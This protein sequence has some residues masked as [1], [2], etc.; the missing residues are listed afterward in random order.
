MRELEHITFGQ[1]PAVRITSGN[2]AQAVVTLFG[3]HI[4][5]WTP[6]GGKEQ[7]FCSSCSALD[8][9]KAIR[10]G[11][12]LIFPQFSERGS[13]MRH[14]FAR[15]S[16]WRLWRSGNEG[17]AGFAEFVLDSSDR[18]GAPWPHEFSLVFRVEVQGDALDLSLRVHN[19]GK[20]PFSF[21]SAL[22]TYFA[23]AD[24]EAVQVNGLQHLRYADQ[25]LSGAPEGKQETAE[26]ACRNTLD[27]I[28]FGTPANLSLHD[29]EKELSLH[30]EGF[31]D[32]VVWNPGPNACLSDMAD[33]EYRRFICIEPAC[34][35][36]I[37]LQPGG[38]W[39]GRHRI[40]QR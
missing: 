5:S 31:A 37:S 36:P 7:L 9:S 27:R 19:T 10:G 15:V 34:I 35:E 22:H 40:T 33:E 20:V 4:V 8:G 29:G 24:I 12:P 3:A 6:A 28:Y 16:E 32:A 13:G 30:Q 38:K 21:S 25:T 11:I 39:L 2:G 17:D 18:L 14:G 1:L 26:L 23:V